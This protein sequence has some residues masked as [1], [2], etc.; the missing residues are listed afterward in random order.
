VNDQCSER[1][2]NNRCNDLKGALPESGH[3]CFNTAGLRQPKVTLVTVREA[4]AVR[5]GSFPPSIFLV[6]QLVAVHLLEFSVIQSLK[7]V[8]DQI[9]IYR[10]F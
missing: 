3:V 9:A 4:D 1:N 6:S 2:E 8:A 5:T 7:H 10:S